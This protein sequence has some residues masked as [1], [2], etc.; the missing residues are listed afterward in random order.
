MR[1]WAPPMRP[2]FSTSLACRASIASSLRGTWL[3]PPR[4]EVCNSVSSMSRTNVFLGAEGEATF[5]A[6]APEV[7]ERRAMGGRGFGRGRGTG[8]VS[9]DS[10]RMRGMGGELPMVLAEV[11]SLPITLLDAGWGAR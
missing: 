10:V 5:I 7:K 4:K 8:S 6:A 3:G 1:L 11:N 2:A 9:S